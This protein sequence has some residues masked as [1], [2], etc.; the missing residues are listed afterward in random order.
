MHYECKNKIENHFSQFYVDIFC[1]LTKNK[2][3][4]SVI[5]Y[6]YCVFIGTLW[7]LFEILLEVQV[8]LLN[9]SV[10][11]PNNYSL[12]NSKIFLY[13]IDHSK[14]VHC[15]NLDVLIILCQ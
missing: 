10:S 1:D 6:L 7:Y 4:P 12:F 9:T 15:T 14:F 5:L 8:W 2:M 13:T 11:F 3:R